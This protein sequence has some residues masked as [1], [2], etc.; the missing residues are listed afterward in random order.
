MG[1]AIP[2]IQSSTARYQLAAGVLYLAG[3]VVTTIAYHV[4]R[5]DKLDGFDP[6]SAEGE[7]YWSV[8][9]KEWV[10]MNHL[11]T[12]APMASAVLLILS[13]LGY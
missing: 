1:L 4:P 3:V 10:R 8:Y 7:R 9:L 12:V 11:R 13:L 6:D 5:N 2:E